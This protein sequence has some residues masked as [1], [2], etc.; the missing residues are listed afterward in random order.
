MAEGDGRFG[1]VR[2]VSQKIVIGTLWFFSNATVWNDAAQRVYIIEGCT[3]LH[4]IDLGKLF[5]VKH[6]HLLICFMIPS[7]ANI[8]ICHDIS[9]ATN[10]TPWFPISQSA[11]NVDH[12]T[13]SFFL[14]Q[15]GF[16]VHSSSNILAMKTTGR[17]REVTLSWGS[18]NGLTRPEL[19]RDGKGQ[20]WWRSKNRHHRRK[21]QDRQRL[22]YGDWK[23]STKPPT[24][25]ISAIPKFG[26]SCTASQDRGRPHLPSS[27]FQGQRHQ[28]PLRDQV[29]PLLARFKFLWLL[30]VV[31]HDQRPTM[32]AGDHRGIGGGCQI[33]RAHLSCP[34]D[35][36]GSRKC[37]EKNASSREGATLKPYSNSFR[38]ST[39][40]L[41]LLM[42]IN[43]FLWSF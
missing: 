20:D 4:L 5:M 12:P 8:N 42:F 6:F 29:A 28:P 10:S 35:P 27:Q 14:C 36:H 18:F 43:S 26:P 1:L 31:R 3:I 41:Y 9:D 33:R 34:H 32:Q 30:L 39:L 40:S 37:S 16:A 15:V 19:S 25:W 38:S 7:C 22:L 24:T 13:I 11:R 17:R 21:H 2:L 23:A